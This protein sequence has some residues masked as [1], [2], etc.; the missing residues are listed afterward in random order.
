MTVVRLADKDRHQTPEGCHDL[1]NVVPA[2]PVHEDHFNLFV[3]R[4]LLDGSQRSPDKFGAI[5][6]GNDDRNFH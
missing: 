1:C 2:S 4:P 6:G 5:V 3:P